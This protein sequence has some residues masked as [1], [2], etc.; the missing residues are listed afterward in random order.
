MMIYDEQALQDVRE[1]RFLLGQFDT[2]LYDEFRPFLGSRILEVGCGLGN[3]LGH[4]SDRELVVGID[5]SADSIEAVRDHFSGR[6]NVL[7]F[8]LDI[9]DP[10]ATSLARYRF[11]TIVS[12]NV[13]E[14]IEHDDLAL[15]HSWEIL[16]PH[17]KCVLIVPAH[18]WLYGTMDRSIGHYRRYTKANL[19]RQLRNTGFR[20]H[21]LKYI[22]M[23]GALG[24]M[25]NGQVLRSVTP[26][27]GQLKL[28]DRFVPSLRKCEELIQAPFGVSLLAVAEKVTG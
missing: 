7:A 16:E 26:P 25:V 4:F 14:H 13:F 20:V 10:E 19:A 24:W 1:K 18:Q 21:Q 28:L 12:L 15:N 23:L 8:H 3:L 22:N 17:G 11:D 5:T 27:S 6:P 9:S 2:W